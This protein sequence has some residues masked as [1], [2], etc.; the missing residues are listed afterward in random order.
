MAVDLERFSSHS[1]MLVICTRWHID[2]LIGRY[3]Q[4]EPEMK[5]VSYPAIAE[6][7]EFWRDST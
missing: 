6:K 3:Q 7:D 5:I 4:L 2:D 1:A